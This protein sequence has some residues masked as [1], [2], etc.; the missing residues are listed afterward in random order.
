MS[1][2]NITG[3][4]FFRDAATEN[5]LNDGRRLVIVVGILAVPEGVPVG[6]EN[7]APVLGREED[8]ILK[9]PASLT[10]ED[11]S[12]Q[13]TGESPSSLLRKPIWRV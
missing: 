4:L 7:M 6:A 2:T 9:L 5:P 11:I 1:N 12:A 10:G 3:Q 13:S 8:G